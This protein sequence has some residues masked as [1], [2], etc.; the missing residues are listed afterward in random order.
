MNLEDAREK[1]EGWH[2][3]YNKVQPQSAIGNKPSM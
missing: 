2:T 3:H 1:M